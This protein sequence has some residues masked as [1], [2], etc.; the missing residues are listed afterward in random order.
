MFECIWN[1]NLSHTLRAAMCKLILTVYI[2]HEPFN[3]LNVPKMCR[4]YEQKLVQKK[5]K[6]F[7]SAIF[8]KTSTKKFEAEAKS[9]ERKGKRNKTLVFDEDSEEI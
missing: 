4:V 5:N 1:T 2:D 6:G 3:P 9:V 7:M 8:S